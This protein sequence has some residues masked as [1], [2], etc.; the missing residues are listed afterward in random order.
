MTVYDFVCVAP[1]RW[2]C[3]LKQADRVVCKKGKKNYEL[4][5]FIPGKPLILIDCGSKTPDYLQ[6]F[7][8]AY[9]TEYISKI[10]YE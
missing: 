4:H 9:Y 5:L 10:I 6:R 8:K 3:L 1:Q 2:T 7:F